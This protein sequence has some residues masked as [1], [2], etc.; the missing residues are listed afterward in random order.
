MSIEIEICS[1]F[2]YCY[3]YYYYHY[4][5]G[6]QEEPAILIFRL[7][8]GICHMYVTAFIWTSTKDEWNAQ[9][10]IWSH[11]FGLSITH[12]LITHVLTI[13]HMKLTQST[14]MD[15]WSLLP[16]LRKPLVIA[17]YCYYYLYFQNSKPFFT[18]CPETPGSCFSKDTETFRAW[19]KIL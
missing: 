7:V 6:Q 11:A 8:L 15:L 14:A 18:I 13:S 10:L 4:H 1:I 5:C 19:R 16:T 12:N 2:L 17:S 9:N 3:Y